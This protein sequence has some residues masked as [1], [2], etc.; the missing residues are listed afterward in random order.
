MNIF[1]KNVIELNLKMKQNVKVL[2]IETDLVIFKSN[3]KKP[4]KKPSYF[5]QIKKSSYNETRSNEP[6]YNEASIHI[7]GLAIHEA[8][9]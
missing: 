9:S 2:S 7:Q 1:R 5:S 6:A 4:K 3:G 8:K